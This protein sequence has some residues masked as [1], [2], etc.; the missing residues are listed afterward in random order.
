LVSELTDK[1]EKANA[2][3]KD[4]SEVE[5]RTEAT[6]RANRDVIVSL[7]IKAGEGSSSEDFSSTFPFLATTK[8]SV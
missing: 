4:S 1:L 5:S 8:L 6:L 7:R 3:D 2:S